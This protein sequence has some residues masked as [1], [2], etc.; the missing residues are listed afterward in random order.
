MAFSLNHPTSSR[1]ALPVKE[2]HKMSTA[3]RC[4]TRTTRVVREC[5]LGRGRYLTQVITV[6]PPANWPN[7]FS[8]DR[9]PCPPL[10]LI[11]QCV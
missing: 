4:T 9:F 8:R 2:S 6:T 11:L 10:L 3:P 7:S 1:M 5:N